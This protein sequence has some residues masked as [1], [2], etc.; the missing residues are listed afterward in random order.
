MQIAIK[1]IM[2][3]VLYINA[4]M[5][6]FTIYTGK[7]C[8]CMYIIYS[9]WPCYTMFIYS[10]K[11]NQNKIKS[12]HN[13]KVQLCYIYQTWTSICIP[14]YDTYCFLY[15]YMIYR[16]TLY[17]TV[18]SFK[19]LRANFHGLVGFFLLICGDA[20]SWMPQFQKDNFK[21]RI[22]F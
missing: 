12:K 4:L 9:Y 16:Y 8:I 10:K 21:T 11:S 17:Y 6:N 19:Y 18:E 3:D 22:S 13:K 15:R 14:L 7:N 1:V 20:I 2:K 5:H